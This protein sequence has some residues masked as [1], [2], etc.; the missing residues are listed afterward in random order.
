M[1]AVLTVRLDDD[2]YEAVRSYAFL[3]GES[4]NSVAVQA[5]RDALCRNADAAVL[6]DRL[7]AARDRL[8]RTIGQLRSP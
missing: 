1:S 6:D 7:E 4:M 5:L 3:T 2:L 8:R